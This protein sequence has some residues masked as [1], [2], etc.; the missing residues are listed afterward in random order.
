MFGQGPPYVLTV[1]Y[2]REVKAL[3]RLH[4]CADSAEPSL[5]ADALSISRVSPFVIVLICS[6]N[7]LPDNAKNSDNLNRYTRNIAPIGN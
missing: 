1:V 6:G 7:F 3:A 2:T 5:L 4:I